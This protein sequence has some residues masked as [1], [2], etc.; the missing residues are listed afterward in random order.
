MWRTHGLQNIMIKTQLAAQNSSRRRF[1]AGLSGD[2]GG[3]DC[4]RWRMR[5]QSGRIQ[6][7][8]NTAVGEPKWEADGVGCAFPCGPYQPPSPH[9][10]IFPWVD[11]VMIW[12]GIFFPLFWTAFTTACSIP[13]Q[14]GTSM[15]TTVT[16][17]MVFCR[18]I[19]VSFSV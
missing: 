16:F 5:R 15:R 8:G 3:G 13:P 2:R 1:F 12:Q 7:P 14:Q 11:S 6:T 9:Y 10:K 17:F 19:S 4:L 18:M